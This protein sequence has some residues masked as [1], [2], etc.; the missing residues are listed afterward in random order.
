MLKLIIADDEKLIRDVLSRFIDWKSMDIEVIAV[1][2]DGQETFQAIEN[3]KP[4][5]VL[6]DIKMPLMTGLELAEYFSKRNEY[7]IEFLFLTAYEEFEFAMAA[8]QNN[9]HHYLLKPLCEELVA[10]EV[11]KAAQTVL[12]RKKIKDMM[13]VDTEK[14]DSVHSECIQAVLDYIEKNYRDPELSLKQIA[15]NYLFMNVDYL[16]RKFHEECG[17][18]FNQYLTDVRIAKAKYLLRHTNDNVGEIAVKIGYGNN[19][20]YFGIAFRK[21]TACTP[22]QYRQKKGTE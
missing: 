7:T 15:D 13:D 16:G 8:I 21:A 18:K 1:C 10:E 4:D 3:H 17:K 14:T 11:K 6:T 20:K 19:P 12:Q 9:V 5:L 2:Q 22:L